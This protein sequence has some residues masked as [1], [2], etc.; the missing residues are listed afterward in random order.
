MGVFS[1]VRPSGLKRSGKNGV[2]DQPILAAERRAA[3][4]REIARLQKLWDEVQVKIDSVADPSEPERVFLRPF[5]TE[6]DRLLL[7][8]AQLEKARATLIPVTN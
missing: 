1:D 5:V 8:I 2:T 4:E 3:I 6:G 7:M